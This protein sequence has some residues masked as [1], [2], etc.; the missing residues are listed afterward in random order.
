MT[1]YVD[2]HIRMMLCSYYYMLSIVLLCMY[3]DIFKCTLTLYEASM[4]LA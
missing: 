4:K 3:A 2:S 1:P